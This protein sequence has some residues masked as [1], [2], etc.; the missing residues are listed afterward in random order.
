MKF[1]KTVMYRAGFEALYR[2]GA[3]RLDALRDE[4]IG[5][6]LT[7]HHVRP[8]RAGDYQPNAELEITPDFLD[9][10][11]DFLRAAG[12]AFVSLEEAAAR[13][14]APRPGPR[15]VAFTLDDGF[16]DNREVALP[17]FRRYGVPFTLF[18]TSGF[19]RRR[20]IIWWKVLETVIGYEPEVEF[21]FEEGTRVFRTRTASEKMRAVDLLAAWARL[22][23]PSLVLERVAAFAER[24]GLD[25]MMPTDRDILTP[26]ELVD[27]AQDPLAT[28]GAHSVTHPNLALLGESAAMAELVGGANEIADIIGRR[29]TF[30]A[31]PYGSGRA[32]GPREYR[33]AAEAGFDLAVTTQPGVLRPEHR[34]RLHALPRIS[35]NGHFQS[36]QHLDV[37]VS[38]A[39]F[40]LLDRFGRRGAA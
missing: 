5:L 14:A 10:A 19:V 22:A 23:E 33:L 12:F 29:P 16:R 30:L 34:D 9:A 3:Y 32:A 35:L 7:L 2:S 40:T 13:I 37:L 17:L 36:A 39:P 15:F 26:D 38:G 18:A 28:I 6:I 4:G 25:P 20:A 1:W 21:R 27:L 11:L 8:R 31:Y 24:Y